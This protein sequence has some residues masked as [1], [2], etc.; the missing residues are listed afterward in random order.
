[1]TKLPT[2]L[3]EADALAF[4]RAEFEW[5]RNN[6]INLFGVDVSVLDQDGAH[7]LARHSLKIK[8]M[9]SVA[10]MMD[11]VSYARAG[12][13]LADEALRE[14]ILEFENSHTQKPD[15]LTAYAM[16][17]IRDGSAPGIRGPQKADNFLRDLAIC[18][19]VSKTC[20][21]F[22]LKPTRS[23]YS[24][25]PSGC[26]IVAQALGMGE[27]GVVEVWRQYGSLNLPVQFSA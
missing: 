15:Y 9:R 1:M 8:A 21:R 27:P 5:F 19:V 18:V 10:G 13:D 6:R 24:R 22:G 3:I 17:V 4:A 12:W 2:T 25:K 11:V 23:R 26:S 20:E 7:Q 16:D 14:L